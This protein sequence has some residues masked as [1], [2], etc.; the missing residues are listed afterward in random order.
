MILI[1]SFS[2]TVKWPL[3]KQITCFI[4]WKMRHLGLFS[5]VGIVCMRANLHQINC[6][7]PLYGQ[8]L[9]HARFNVRNSYRCVVECAAAHATI[10]WTSG[11]NMNICR[12]FLQCAPVCAGPVGDWKKKSWG[13]VDIDAVSHRDRSCHPSLQS[14]HFHWHPYLLRCC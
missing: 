2:N 3:K 1:D 5:D 12:V 4:F 10:A 13:I 8:Q 7:F 9:K 11:H 6:S 14:L